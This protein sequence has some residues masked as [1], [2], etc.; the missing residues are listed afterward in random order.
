MKRISL[1]IF[2]SLLFSILLSF[3]LATKS[4]AHLQTTNITQATATE[5]AQKTSIRNGEGALTLESGA[6]LA[7]ELQGT[8][9]V[10]KA[11]VGDQVIL[12]TTETIK[13]A[14]QPIVKKGAKLIG[15]ITEVRQKSKAEATSSIGV[16]FDRLESGEM[17]TPISA[18]ITSVTQAMT[19]ANLDDRGFSTVAGAASNGRAG[20]RSQAS[21]GGLLGGVTQT[22]SGVL[23]TT[24]QTVGGAV[25]STTGTVGGAT[26]TVGSTLKGIQLSQST[27]ST[28]EGGSTLSLSGGN[29]RLEKGASFVLTLNETATLG[30]TPKSKER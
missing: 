23:D 30:K 18:T 27:A 25:H 12:K 5:T 17:A 8:L 16:V 21:G 26:N 28:S 7:A 9:D 20:T 6:R 4:A 1:T 2:L 19:R 24:T 22:V 10:R 14:G 29:L 13:S 3:L 11:R 15:H